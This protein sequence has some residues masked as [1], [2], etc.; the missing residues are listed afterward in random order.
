MVVAIVVIVPSALAAVALGKDGAP[1][2]FPEESFPSWRNSPSSSSG[3]P[4]SGSIRMCSLHL[5]DSPHMWARWWDGRRTPWRLREHFWRRRL[6]A[7]ELDTCKPS[8][9][10]EAAIRS[11]WK[12]PQ[13]RTMS[14]AKP[15]W[16]QLCA[17]YRDVRNSSGG[18]E[19]KKW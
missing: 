1:S 18:R 4:R 8:K 19:R 7:N 17:I 13:D 3:S 2:F 14:L 6:R 9:E 16:R 10:L 5:Y 11:I 12:M 15:E